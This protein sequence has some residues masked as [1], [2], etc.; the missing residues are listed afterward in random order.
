MRISGKMIL[1]VNDFGSPKKAFFTTDCCVCGYHIFKSFWEAPLGS[2]V[3][4]KN[5]VDPQSLI[6]DKFTIASVNS[7][8]VNV[9]HIPKYISKLIYF[10]S[11]TIYI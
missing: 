1:M 5:E 10:F 2:I 9:G 6:Q 8:L 11:Y 7:D 4:T 3:I